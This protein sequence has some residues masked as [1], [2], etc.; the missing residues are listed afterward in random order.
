M[1]LNEMQDSSVQLESV[2]PPLMAESQTSLHDGAANDKHRGQ[3]VVFV[4][5]GGAPAVPQESP[6]GAAAGKCIKRVRLDG[7]DT[8]TAFQLRQ[9][10]QGSLKQAKSRAKEYMLVPAD[11]LPPIV[12]ADSLDPAIDGKILSGFTRLEAA[13]LRNDTEITVELRKVENRAEALTIAVQENV[14]NGTPLRFEEI[15][16]IVRQLH[17]EGVKQVVIAE[18]VNRHESNVSRMLKNDKPPCVRKNSWSKRAASALLTLE[19]LQDG[20]S[21]DEALHHAMAKVVMAYRAVIDQIK[22]SGK[23]L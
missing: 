2:K 3:P 19:E 18:R 20:L 9:Q 13:K 17:K 6:S 10:K 1:S 14:S 4:S 23:N 15:K 16:S 5:P 8:D 11:E 7:I 12:I 21:D 22:E